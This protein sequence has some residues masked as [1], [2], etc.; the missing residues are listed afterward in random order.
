MHLKVLPYLYTNLDF[1]FFFS[2]GIIFH[3]KEASSFI[4]PSATAGH[5]RLPPILELHA[6]HQSPLPFTI[7]GHTL[8][9]SRI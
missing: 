7:S 3:P 5:L 9:S 4:Y 6:E 2:N 1:F 8:P